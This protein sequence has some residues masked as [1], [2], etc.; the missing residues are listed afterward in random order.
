MHNSEDLLTNNAMRNE[1]VGR[2]D[3]LD[4]VKELLLLPNTDFATTEQVADYYE[5]EV[6]TIVKIF[7]RNREE[8]MSDGCKVYRKD[9]VINF[10]S[11]QDVHLENVVGKAIVTFEDKQMI[12]VPNRG[13][14]LFPRRAILRVGM[15]LRDSVVAKEV[16]TQ[17]LNIEEKTSRKIKV[18]DINQEQQL[19]LNIVYSDELIERSV[20]VSELLKYKNRHIEEINTKLEV[21]ENKNQA[22]AKGILKWDAREAINSM[23]RKIAANVFESHGKYAFA[24]AW[25]K[26]RAH[27][28][29]KHSI[30]VTMRLNNQPKGATIFDVLDNNELQLL[31]QSCVALCEQYKIDIHDLMIKSA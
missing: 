22:L 16:R 3:V 4:K 28:L 18:Q 2:V 12:E 17:L 24:K 10:L 29:Y 9:N 7:T 15:L 6:G 13:L 23:A 14:R 26:I 5:V 21:S 30:G 20:A 11:G 8:L 31:V 25:E 19:V 1:L 27:M